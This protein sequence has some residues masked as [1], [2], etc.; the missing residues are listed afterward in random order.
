MAQIGPLGP[1]PIGPGPVAWNGHTG[2][3]RC[4]TDF[5][6]PKYGGP[7]IGT[8]KGEDMGLNGQIRVQI[9][10]HING[11]VNGPK[12]DIPTIWGPLGRPRYG[13]SEY[14]TQMAEY[15]PEL[16]RG[17][18]LDTDTIRIRASLN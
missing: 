17:V 12:W 3:N 16:L 8:P 2:Q 13:G 4:P 9:W 15:G 10:T 6:D 18:L 11:P 14:G 7:E 1:R 5:G